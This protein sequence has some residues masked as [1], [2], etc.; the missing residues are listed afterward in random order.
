MVQI[1]CA[2][3]LRELAAPQGAQLSSIAIAVR[4]IL[5]Q[6]GLQVCPARSN[7]SRQQ[8]GCQR[9]QE[10]RGWRAVGCSGSRGRACRMPACACMH[11][12][13]ACDAGRAPSHRH[14]QAPERHQLA[15]LSL[16]TAKKV[17]TGSSAQGGWGRAARTG[18]A[19][20]PRTAPCLLPACLL[21]CA[22][23]ALIL[24]LHSYTLPA[25]GEPASL[26]NRLA[27]EVRAT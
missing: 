7:L 9:R 22:L 18:R 27:G 11:R 19:S 8:L 21:S 15:H 25:C 20:A 10:G 26:A 23:N 17:S 13:A 3:Q 6:K 2:E 24:V 1:H 14:M 16:V 12:H 4:P 5:L